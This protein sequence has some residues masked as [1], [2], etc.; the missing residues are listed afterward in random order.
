MSARPIRSP[1]A[2]LPDFLRALESATGRKARKSGDEYR[3][4][5]PAHGGALKDYN[6]SVRA[7]DSRIVA[8][9]FSHGCEFPTVAAAIGYRSG[10][11]AGLHFP[12]PPSYS[13][14]RET[15]TPSAFDPEIPVESDAFP[16]STPKG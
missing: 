13:G 6:L 3:M 5:C 7:G 16:I 2:E 15:N 14:K 1:D 12:F 8:A 9:C 4:P 11:D 10:N